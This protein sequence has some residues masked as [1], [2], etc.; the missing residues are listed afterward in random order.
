MF[1]EPREKAMAAVMIG[2]TCT[3]Y[4]TVGSGDSIS[5]VT[6]PL[7]SALPETKTLAS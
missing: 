7:V 5:R 3:S 4:T 1:A 2:T 6:E